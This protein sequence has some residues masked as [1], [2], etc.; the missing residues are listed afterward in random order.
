M[1]TLHSL[2]L[3]LFTLSNPW[4]NIFCTTF[5]FPSELYTRSRENLILFVILFF[6]SFF[7]LLENT[8]K[9]EGLCA[10][11]PPYV[12]SLGILDEVSAT[13]RHFAGDVADLAYFRCVGATLCVTLS[14]IIESFYSFDNP[15]PYLALLSSAL[16]TNMHSAAV[17]GAPKNTSGHVFYHC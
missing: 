8:F 9:I 16:M 3:C 6:K 5:Y 14:K 10:R 15:L 17:S 11:S 13:V 4:K 2:T 7:L 12:T 1:R